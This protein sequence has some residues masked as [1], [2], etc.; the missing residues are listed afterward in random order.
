MAEGIM[1]KFYGHQAYVQ[2][3]GVAHQLEI[4]GFSIAVCEELGVKLDGHRVRSFDDMAKWG[5]DISG[6]DL[7]VALS[8]VSYERVRDLT[9][10]YHLDVEYWLISDP[11][12]IGE[13]RDAKLAAYR[14]TR[15]QIVDHMV[16]RFGK[17]TVDA[18]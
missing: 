13:T 18:T 12:G 1:K 2:S 15:D 14:Q 17:P 7:I 11:T 5:D 8:P 10:Q 6:F 4:D 9:G 16:A 3:A